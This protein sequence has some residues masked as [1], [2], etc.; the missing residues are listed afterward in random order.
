MQL[1]P[2][3]PAQRAEVNRILWEQ[4][5]CPPSVSRGKAIDTT[6]LHG[7]FMYGEQRNPGCRYLQFENGACEI[8]TLNSFS[9]NAASARFL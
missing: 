4:W 5:H 1:L 3:T 2:I 7:F 6:N 8:V 9:K